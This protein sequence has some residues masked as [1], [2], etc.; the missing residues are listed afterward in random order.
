MTTLEIV[1]VTCALSPA[2]LT[3]TGWPDVPSQSPPN[4][5]RNVDNAE[6]SGGLA[7][8]PG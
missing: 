7:A 8:F 4:K 6:R 1:L 5:K 2:P 3:R